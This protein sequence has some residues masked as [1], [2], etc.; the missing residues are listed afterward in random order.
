MRQRNAAKLL[1]INPAREVLLFRF[2]HKGDALDGSDHWA[3][4][5]G[6]LEAGE[7]F[8]AAAVREL[9]EETGL[10]VDNVGACVTERSFSMMLPS[11][12]TV[13]SVERYFVVHTQDTQLSR[14]G[15]TA[16][17]MRVMTDHKWWSV[18][19]LQSTTQTVWPERLIE[20]LGKA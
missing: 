10:R 19:E 15:W 13:W 5:G 14:E 16:D 12:E 17:E 3:A 7:T 6:G 1:V 2:Q 8:E 20:M 11:G 4:P 18:A 9:L